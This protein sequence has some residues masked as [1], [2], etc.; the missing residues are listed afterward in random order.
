MKI[1]R[2]FVLGL[3]VR[4][5]FSAKSSFAAPDEYDDSQSHPLRIAAYLMH[6]VVGWRN[7]LCFDPFIFS[8]ARPTAGSV[9]WSPSAS[10]G[11]GRAAAH[12]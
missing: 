7:G 5:R 3:I 4:F 1:A 12:V 6:P 2:S 11:I 9:F 10:A 8:S